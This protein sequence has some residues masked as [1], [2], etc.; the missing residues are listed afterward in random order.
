MSS[1]VTWA[2]ACADVEG[3]LNQI[4]APS[5][6]PAEP[7]DVRSVPLAPVY[8]YDALSDLEAGGEPGDRL[9]AAG[10]IEDFEITLSSD[11]WRSLR[12]HP[13]EEVAG[14][15]TWRGVEYSA[16]IKIKGSSSYRS[17]QE[18]ASFKVDVHQYERERRI[19]GL[20]RLTLNN[21]IQDPTMLREHAYYWLAAQLGVPA[22][23]QGFAR[24]TVNG[25]PYGVYSLVETMDGRLM[26]RLYP[27]DHDGNLYEA[28][29][30][31][32]TSERNWF[33]VQVDGG[34]I[35]TPDDIDEL[36]DTI[37]E[38]GHDEFAGV[39]G[40][41][42]DTEAVLRYLALD[43]VVGNDDGYVFN[44]H[45]YHAYHLAFADRWVLLPWGT[46]RSFTEEVSPYGA[47]DKPIVGELALR[48]WD[49][50]GCA[51]ELHEAIEEVL[52]VWEDGAFPEMLA[53]TGALI[54][55]ACEDD[56]R[57]EKECDPEDIQG[58]VEARAA[59]VWGEIE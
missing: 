54:R 39:F 34:I 3:N 19:D 42:F 27:D 20:K 8:S 45:N 57:R 58:F 7:A 47:W 15:L 10:M 23:R 37:E 44:H 40:A 53:T 13:D 51:H 48:C 9:F 56:P 59:Y 2:L 43:T 29:G 41:R 46:D 6:M 12:D 31:D 1:I 5:H 36:V 11:A 55:E 52:R 18:K 26:K 21:M 33:D 22:P 30:A 4:G 49:D 28:S 35:P 38:A 14:T 25:E 17:I 50:D 24:V 16:G 32:F